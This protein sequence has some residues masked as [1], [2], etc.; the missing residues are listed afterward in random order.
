MLIS[1]EQSPKFLE[2]QKSKKFYR[3]GNIGNHKLILG[4]GEQ[5]TIYQQNKR[6]STHTEPERASR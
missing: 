5:N 4:A 6:S 3:T 2:E 1:R